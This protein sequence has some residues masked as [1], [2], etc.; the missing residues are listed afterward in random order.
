MQ[1]R[2][3]FFLGGV[4]LWIGSSGDPRGDSESS[5]AAH[6][7]RLENTHTHSAVCRLSGVLADLILVYIVLNVCR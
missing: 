4:E 2:S 7:V 1:G 5:V 6:V 3:F